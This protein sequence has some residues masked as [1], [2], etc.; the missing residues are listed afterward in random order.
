FAQATIRLATAAVDH[1]AVSASF[2]ANL[3][4]DLT[5]AY[6][7][8]VAFLPGTGAGIGLPG[9]VAIDV[10]LQTPF[11]YDPALGDLAIDVDCPGGA[12]CAGG[13][14]TRRDGQTGAPASRVYASTSYPTANGITPGHGAVVEVG[15]VLANS[16]LAAFATDVGG[17]PTPVTV[18]FT[19]RSYT[20]VA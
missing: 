19:D 6:S 9:T 3:G 18:H 16:L 2:A 8:A 14:L 15:Y 5:T 10:A 1:A 7:G 17:G 20:N 4:A 13:T 12:T 11:V